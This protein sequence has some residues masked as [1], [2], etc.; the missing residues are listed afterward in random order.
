V[1]WK[2]EE[3]NEHVGWRKTQF[4]F[5][6]GS[7]INVVKKINNLYLLLLFVYFLNLIYVIL[8]NKINIKM[9]FILNY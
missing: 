9:K 2:K 4:F 3:E 5:L 7:Y 1:I 8:I 6:Y